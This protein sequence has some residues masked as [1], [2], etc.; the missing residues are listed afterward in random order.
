MLK[1][2]Y[3]NLGKTV[4][5]VALAFLFTS[6]ASAPKKINPELPITPAEKTLSDKNPDVKYPI[7]AAYD[8][9]E[10][11]NRNMY[12]FNH[13][14]DK[15]IYLPIVSGYEF[16]MPDFLEDGV[17]N[18]FKNIGEFKNLTNSILQFKA[19]SSAKTL[20]RFVVNTTIGLAG[21]FDP[22]TKLGIPRQNED[23]GQ[24]L[25]Y[26]GMGAG[27]YLVLPI[28]GPSSLRDTVGLIGDSAARAALVDWI[29]PLENAS[30]EDLIYAGIYALEALDARH[31]QSFRYYE[32][33]SPF[34][35]ELI[36]FLYLSKRKLDI[37]NIEKPQAAE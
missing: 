32:A 36:R 35:Y 27:P 2:L 29:D 31:V 18:F 7:A 17:S 1:K 30:D 10:G 37:G 4:L 19:G 26:Y 34:E 25:G 28:F 5:I 33:G 20:G 11:F 9:W 22:A 8:P 16:I 6:C 14:F 24:T 21:L 23:L 13:H 15:Y 12:N 3:K